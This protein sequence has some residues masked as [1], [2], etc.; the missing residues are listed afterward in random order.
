M[1]YWRN[2]GLGVAMLAMT[3]VANAN[4]GNKLGFNTSG[5]S[6][7]A[8][9]NPFIDKFKLSRGWITS[10][11]Y[12][13]QNDR[14]IDPG[15]TKRSS[16]NTK[17][18]DK[19]KVDR[20][21][22]P[23][24]LPSAAEAPV[25][26]SINAIWDL[27]E[28]FTLGDYVVTYEGDVDIKAHGDITVTSESPGRM[29]FSL[30][31]TKRN[32]RLHVTRINPRNYLRNVKVIPKRF[33]QVASRQKF[34][35][36]YLNT[37]RPFNSIRFMP[38]Q[39]TTDTKF[40][41]WEQRTTP[42]HA[43]YNGN[44]GMPIETMVELSNQVNA[45]PWFSMPHLAD[46]TLLYRFAQTV[47]QN[48]KPNLKVYVEYSNET[49]NF[50]YPAAH[51]AYQEGRKRWP[52]AY[53]KLNQWARN[54]K[55]GLNYTALR[56]TQICDI[57]KRVFAN[58]SNRVVCVASA[59]GSAPS[60]GEEILSCPL[61]GGN[62]AQK[63]D[64]YGVAPY[65]GDYIAR[66]ENRGLVRQW[67]HSGPAGMNNLFKEILHG[68]F[69]NNGI[70]GGAVAEAVKSR[71]DPNIALVKKH[72]VKLV[73]YEA[74]QHLLRVDGKH[75]IKDQKVFE[76]FKNAQTDPRMLQAYRQYLQAWRRSGAD[77]MMHF[78]GIGQNNNH[79]YFHMLERPE[80][81]NSAK[82]RAL[83]EYLRQR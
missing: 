24:R 22:W 40:S 66:I 67:A 7:I 47:K 21:G 72:G 17:E 69:I 61:A 78:R 15:C 9:S 14:A 81:P 49:W 31:S 28:N 54:A 82:Y 60:M 18:T 20:F 2:F 53:P 73:A 59:Y 16:F 46:D 35:P 27:G 65:F 77:I 36:D 29:E 11:Q 5:L 23:M 34:N 30:N 58:Q 41:R 80:N 68:S 12:D 52:N 6:Q 13:W 64:A 25:Y 4:P 56:T 48:L 55:W 70:P 26:T 57:W 32:L 8:V 43:F 76:M 62:C 75:V 10:C 79:E 19:V 71:I 1:K 3:S 74:G 51:H 33:V 50:L 42:N 63:I 39:N 45:A 83:T 37:I 44:A 38:W